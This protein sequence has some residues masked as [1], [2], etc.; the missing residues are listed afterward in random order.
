M[1]ARFRFFSFF[2]ERSGKGSTL[3]SFIM[4][5]IKRHLGS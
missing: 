1:F 2:C 3:E 4:I 5:I